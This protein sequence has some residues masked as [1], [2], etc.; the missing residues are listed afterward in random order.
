MEKYGIRGPALSLFKTYL[1]NRNHF[2]NI[3]NVSSNNCLLNIGVPQGSVLGPLLFLLYINDMPN[4]TSLFMRLFADDTFLAFQHKNAKKL[5]KIVHHE[6][7]K[8]A[9]WLIDNRLS[10]NVLKSKFMLVS[11]QKNLKRKMFKLNIKRKKL[12]QTS[13][14]KYL[15]VYFDEALNW[16][17]H[18]EHVCKKLSRVTGVLSKLR[19]SLDI[20]LLKTIYYALVYPHILYGVMSW[21]CASESILK[22]MKSAQNRVVKIM[23]FIPY[24]SYD[25]NPVYNEIE[26]LQME[27]IYKLEVGKFMYKFSNHL[28]PEN[29]EE[30]FKQV[31]TIHNHKSI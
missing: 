19:Y 27:K 24:G 15:G 6:L 2:V 17:A 1:C 10:L 18:V 26:I 14:Y 4:V 30:Y 3:G 12:E 11:R 29:F 23:K 13:K 28:L 7:D 16:N 20:D 31:S 5:N 25:M 22:K 9:D 8:V 21:G